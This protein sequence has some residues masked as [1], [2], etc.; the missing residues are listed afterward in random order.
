MT[1]ITDNAAL[2]ALCARLRREPFVT[3]DTEFMRETTYWPLLC[4]IQLAGPEDA[5]VVD[6]LAPDLV[7]SIHRK[8]DQPNLAL[9]IIGNGLVN[10]G[11]LVE[12]E[13]FGRG[14][15]KRPAKFIV[16]LAT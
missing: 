13:I 14:L 12:L 2:E 5:F 10:G 7:F 1:L 16:R 6:A 15:I 4:V 3:V 9:T 11:A 8:H